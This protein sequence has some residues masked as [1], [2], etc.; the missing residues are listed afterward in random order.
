MDDELDPQAVA[1][2]VAAVPTVRL[3]KE[4]AV[5]TH[6]PGRRIPGVRVHGRDVEVHVAAV[7]PTPVGEVAAA[8]R[9][10]LV[11][12]GAGNVDVVVEDVVLPGDDEIQDAA[13]RE[14]E[15]PSAPSA[16][17]DPPPDH[18]GA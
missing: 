13:P 5:G 12:L 8:V 10:A 6:L 9:S 16:V 17:I 4:S 7:W 15:A 14:P 2:A 1:A 3:P 18:T 11:P